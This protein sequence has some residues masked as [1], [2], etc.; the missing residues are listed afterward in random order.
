MT[1]QQVSDI[2]FQRQRVRVWS[3]RN[4]KLFEGV[5]E[6]VPETLNNLNVKF[7]S[8]DLVTDYDNNAYIVVT[9]IYVD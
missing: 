1:V 6:K 7:I 4:K 2:I 9:T 5:N 8:S 3:I